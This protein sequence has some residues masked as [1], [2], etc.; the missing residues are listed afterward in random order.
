MTRPVPPRLA[1]YVAVVFL[2]LVLVQLAASLLFYNAIDRQTLRDDHARRVAELLVVS[3]RVHALD[4]ARLA[5]SMTTRHLSARVA[6]VPLV[7]APTGDAALMAIAARI[8]EW[9]P[10]LADRS[11]NLATTRTAGG[12]RDL[13]GSIRLGEDD[14][15]NFR[16]RDINSMW[17]VALRATA[18]TLATTLACLALGL[19]ALHLLTRPLR[20]LTDAAEAIGKGRQVTIR[21]GGPKDLRNLGHAMNVMQARIERLLRDQALS[22]EAISHDL[23]T[24]LSRQKVAS[25]LIDDPE[26]GGLVRESVDEMEDLLASLQRFLRAQHLSAE[27]ETVDLAPYLTEV[28]AGFGDRAKIEVQGRST[29]RTYREPLAL[30]VCALVE[31]AVHFGERAKVSIVEEDRHHTVFI[32]DE[33]PGIPPDYFEAIL[34]PFFRLDE[35]RQRD[36]KGFGLGIPMAHRLMMRF[37]GGL[38][39]AASPS[40]G[41]IARLKVPTPQD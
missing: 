25:E 19:G 5:E 27:P 6:S 24:P 16:S 9:E 21:E 31:N 23:R 8:V 12:G 38:S 30:A 20:R 37:H 40:G 33:G 2:V 18:L 39:F 34:D 28:L 7:A 22:F 13:I 17:P 35:A 29:A 14:W 41:L 32:E 3:D 15:L 10:S 36:T 1:A 26:I 4:P 11:L